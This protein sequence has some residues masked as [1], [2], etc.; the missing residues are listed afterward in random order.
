MLSNA[1]L[2]L[3][4][5]HQHFGP[6]IFIQ[7]SDLNFWTQNLLTQNLYPNVLNKKLDL[8]EVNWVQIRLPKSLP[9]TQLSQ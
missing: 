9:I 8:G 7:I 1:V 4:F 3:N 5:W 6:G 2:V